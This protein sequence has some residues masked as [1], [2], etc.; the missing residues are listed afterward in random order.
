MAFKPNLKFMEQKR[1]GHCRA[2]QVRVY[3]KQRQE[4]VPIH[5]VGLV[6]RM[7]RRNEASKT[8]RAKPEGREPHAMK[9]EF[10][11][12]LVRDHC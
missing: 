10:K 3:H 9:S 8:G 6:H 1:I 12:Q 2:L 7:L 11:L 4:D 5:Q